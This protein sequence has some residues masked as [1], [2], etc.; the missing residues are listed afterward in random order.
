MHTLYEQEKNM[1][2]INTLAYFVAA[3]VMNKT[4]FMRFVLV[5]LCGLKLKMMTD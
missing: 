4:G 2:G 1:Q 5:G 3:S